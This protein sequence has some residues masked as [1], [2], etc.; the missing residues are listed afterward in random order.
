MRDRQGQALAARMRTSMTRDA[1]GSGAC[2]IIWVESAEVEPE[3]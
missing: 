1:V 2:E 3:N